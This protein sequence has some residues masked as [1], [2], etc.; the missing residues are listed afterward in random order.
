[1]FS[2]S[3]IFVTVTFLFIF[4][5]GISL[6]LII[7]QYFYFPMTIADDRYEDFSFTFKNLIINFKFVYFFLVPLVILNIYKLFTIKKY[8]LNKDF[9]IFLSLITLCISLMFHQLNTQNQLFIL[10][11]IPLICS[12]LHSQLMTIKFKK[13]KSIINIMLIICI[14][15]SVKYHLRYNEGTKFHEM[16][17]INFNLAVDARI[18][19]K[20][21]YGL[22]WV[23]P[24]FQNNPMKE[25]DLIKKTLSD[26]RNNNQKKMVMTNYSF[27][28]SLL[29]E[30]L[31]SPS[32]WYTSNG[33]AYPVRNNKY[34]ENYRNY[35]VDLIM[36]KE[37]EVIY[38]IEPY[39]R[40]NF[41][42]M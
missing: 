27:F 6:Q 10:F 25:I 20:K 40:T 8:F 3:L 21:L 19:D 28:S 41:L 22:R 35:L 2:S 24:S 11:L 16:Q 39:P 7:Y 5:Q 1:M 42:D 23:S 26:L 15:F 37:I 18:I 13:K 17:N 14:F 9:F 32:R 29:D 4:F 12:F 31:N 33:A 30:N 36:R 34:Y 38:V